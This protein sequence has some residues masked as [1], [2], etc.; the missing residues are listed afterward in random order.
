NRPAENIHHGQS[1]EIAESE[2]RANR[3]VYTSGDHDDHHGKYD[4]AE[5]TKLP[6]RNDQAGWTEEIG[7]QVAEQSH[8]DDEKGKWRDV[9]DPP[10]GENLAEHVVGDIFVPCANKSLTQ[11]WLARRAAVPSGRDRN[12]VDHHFLV[13]PLVQSTRGDVSSRPAL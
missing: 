13:R 8:R 1:R 3:E 12:G 9:V 5:L 11:A 10:L 2:V 7:D 6:Q 4:K